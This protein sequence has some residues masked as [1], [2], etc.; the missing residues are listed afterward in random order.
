[1][2]LY[3]SYCAILDSP[4]SLPRD[5]SDV[6]ELNTS[7]WPSSC[8]WTLRPTFVYKMTK[9]HCSAQARDPCRRSG[10]ITISINVRA[11]LKNTG[12][13]D[14]RSPIYDVNGNRGL[15]RNMRF[16]V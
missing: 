12:R 3:E 15:Q 7:C 13:I 16:A 4:T 5:K 6:A 14:P 11:D 8:C 9:A 1:M 2:H 10:G